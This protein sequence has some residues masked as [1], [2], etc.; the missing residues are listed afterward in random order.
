MLT[1]KKAEIIYRFIWIPIFTARDCIKETNIHT[2]GWR[3]LT[4]RLHKLQ[5]IMWELWN[6]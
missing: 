4:S 5:F 6:K 3:K 1:D 2:M